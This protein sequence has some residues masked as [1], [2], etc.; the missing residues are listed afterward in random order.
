MLWY[1]TSNLWVAFQEVSPFIS[2]L[3]FIGMWAFG[4]FVKAYFKHKQPMT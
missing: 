2:K 3:P 4:I 1:R